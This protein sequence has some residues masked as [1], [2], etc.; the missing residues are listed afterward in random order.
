MVRESHLQ[1]TP[2]CEKIL[3]NALPHRF[4]VV[5]D[6]MRFPSRTVHDVPGGSGAYSTV[7]ARMA[8]SESSASSIGCFILVGEDFP[9]AISAKFKS[10]GMQL[11]VD[12]GA[13][14]GVYPWFARV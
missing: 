9:A 5:I 7:G 6:E 11:R 8:A 10:W 13:W 3:A 2:Q 4:Q 14:A 12:I 1:P